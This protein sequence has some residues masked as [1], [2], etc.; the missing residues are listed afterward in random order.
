MIE[1]RDISSLALLVGKT[2][3]ILHLDVG[4]VLVGAGKS[5]VSW[6]TK[7]LK[8]RAQC[9]EGTHQVF[10]HQVFENGTRLMYVEAEFP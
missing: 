9:E 1:P 8:L 10:V 3:W 6:K 2:V 7:S 5:G 4:D